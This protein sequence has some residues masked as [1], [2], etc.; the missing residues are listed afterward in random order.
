MSVYAH[1]FSVA[2]GMNE[3]FD[4]ELFA[5]KGVLSARIMTPH[6]PLLLVNAHVSHVACM[7]EV[8]MCYLCFS[9]HVIFIFS[10][11][12]NIVG[13]MHSCMFKVAKGNS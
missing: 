10:V 7:W 6:G 1:Q 2:G 12:I 4:G 3:F 13:I 8:I 11:M 9:F 5:G